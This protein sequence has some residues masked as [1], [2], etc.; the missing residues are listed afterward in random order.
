MKDEAK[1]PLTLFRLKVEELVE[2]KPSDDDLLKLLQEYGF[3][4]NMLDNQKE[5]NYKIATKEVL[6][7]LNEPGQISITIQR[8]LT[9]LRKTTGIEAIGIRLQDGDDFPY[10]DQ[11]GFSS[12]FVL[13]ENSLIDFDEKGHK[14]RDLDGNVCLS[15]T[16]GMVI[17]GKYEPSNPSVTSGGS[18]WTN[19]SLQSLKLLSNNDERFHPRNKCILFKYAS[20]ALIPI[21]TNEK[22]FGMI[23]FNDLR[24]NVFNSEII[25]ILEG[26]ALHIGSTIV[27][28]KAEEILKE[29][30]NRRNAI[31]QTTMDGFWLIDM[32]GNILEVND[33][34]CR[35][36]GY[37]QQELLNMNI[38]ELDSIETRKQT[39]DHIKKVVKCAEDRFESRHRR[40]D[41]R[42][43]DVEISCKYQ[44]DIDGRIIVFLHD[45]TKRKQAEFALRESEER[46]RFTLQNIL[47]P[48][49]VI[50]DLELDNII[51]APALQRLLEEYFKLAQV[52]MA[53]IDN[54]GKVLVRI[55]WQNVCTK[56]HRVHP[57]SCRNCIESDVYLTNGI[58]DGTFKLYQCK[59]GMWDMATPILIGGEHKGNLF[60]GQF[61]FE[62][63]PID[64]DTFRKQSELFG[65]EE[66]DYFEALNKVPRLTKQH[67]E[68]VK[69]FLLMLSHL[70]SQLSYSNVKLAKAIA[71]QKQVEK[72]LLE[73]D[74]LI[75]KAQEI[76]NLGSWSLDLNTKSLTWSDQIFQIFGLNS[77][78]FPATYEGFLDA[79]HPDDRDAVDRTYTDTIQ[80]GMDHFE[81]E[82]RIVRKN[83]GELRYVNEKCEHFKDSTGK[84]FRSVGMI[85]DITERKLKEEALRK[86]NQT[87]AALSKSSQA[88]SHSFDETEYLKRVCQIVVEDT[89][90]S[91]VWI[92][93]AEK[94]VK[95][96]VRPVASAGF[97]DDY[98]NSIQVR[99]DDS[100]FGHGPTGVAIRTGKIALCNNMSTDPDFKPWREQALKRGFASSIVL[101]LKSGDD[102]FGAI[103][104]YS[105]QTD[106]FF[107]DEIKLLTELASDLASG[108]TTIHLRSAQKLAEETLSKSYIELEKLV[109]ARTRELQ[110]TNKLLNK[111]I[112]TR[113]QHELN[114]LAAEKK[115]R[116]V[117]DFTANWEFWM[118]HNH[119]LYYC[120]PSCERITG[121]TASEFLKDPRLFFFIVHPA[122]RRE[123]LHHNKNELNY[124]VYKN[125]IQYRIIR[126]DGSI[127][128]LAH[129]CQPVFDEN[130]QFNGT[131]GSNK[132]ITERKITEAQLL[133]SNEK[134]KLLSE[135]I[136]DGIFICKN[137]KFEYANNA[138][139]QLFGYEKGEL[140]H[141]N[142]T[143][144]V[145]TDRKVELDIFL[146]STGELDQ[147]FNL[148]V[149]CIK[150]DLST[151]IVEMLL[152]FN[153]I[154]KMVYGV[155]QDVTERKELQRNILKAIIQ[156]EEK[157][158]SH[159]SKELHDGLGPLLTTIKIYLESLMRP[160]SEEVRNELV[161]NAHD[162]IEESLITVKEISN[163]LSPHLLTNYGLQSAIKSFIDK[164]NKTTELDIVLES[165]AYDRMPEEIEAT[166]YR[167]IIEC[168]NNTMKHGNAKNIF[169]K[170][171]ISESLF[172][173]NYIDDGIGFDVNEVL[174][175]QTGL[176]LFNLQNRI[177]NIGGKLELTSMPGKGVNYKFYITI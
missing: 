149:R 177:Q 147:N 125:E 31:L 24:K 34:Y 4:P 104:I 83:T 15:C 37:S 127:R 174:S 130:G 16:C 2:N 129:I 101:P 155:I 48:D 105:N 175:K 64:I 1:S 89:D 20:I 137:G 160:K 95:K 78:E 76:A 11:S 173:V 13:T 154:E 113:K 107:E 41:G 70:I 165:N 93:Y 36:S 53:I 146:N 169:I 69:S 80:Q 25:E 79:I 33:I 67:I 10:L 124:K 114:L 158:R 94:D 71:Q 77:S 108:I 58:S 18:W 5:D 52:P 110:L 111:E 106:S 35:M 28:K 63:E 170:M 119:Q 56:F 161:L 21:R 140:E 109:E 156:T 59:N 164:L 40:K 75:L 27:R 128:W 66:K 163:N 166:L 121:Y 32:Q 26:I 84:I 3:K 99:W 131:R 47:S 157:E 19:D 57:E 168:I 135:N 123:F 136:N 148:E 74:A 126:K 115:Y 82:H 29:S 97:K 44:T 65:F 134:Y 144:L 138:V 116:T 61:F 152:K 132:D 133:T 103:C 171:N 6:Q 141:L 162:I 17:S 118:G 85:Q 176:G 39:Y 54:H 86:L 7:I 30:E 81:I 42:F 100:E 102:V 92:G 90:F 22:N 12:D 87:L 46:A 143:D 139:Y 151:I 150:K 9:V 112:D 142:L 120:S 51:D 73:K 62:N 50:A 117:A 122:D 38:S 96:T 167:S 145:Q 45:I 23:Q 153:T 172:F 98:I 55:G 60:M 49:M 88:M 159:F 72:T 43:I 14:C 91:M 68:I 8:V